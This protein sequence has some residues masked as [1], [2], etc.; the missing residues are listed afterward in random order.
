M[1]ALQE[2]NGSRLRAIVK[3][4]GHYYHSRCTD[5]DVIDSETGDATDTQ[6]DTALAELLRDFMTWIYR[7]LETEHDYQ[8]SDETVDESIRANEYEFTESGKRAC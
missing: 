1:T 8:L 6:A 7:Q 4:S 5:I 2:A 3:H